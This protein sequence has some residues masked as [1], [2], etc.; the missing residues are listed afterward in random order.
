MDVRAAFGLLAIA[1]IAAIA[2]TTGGGPILTVSLVVLGL[3]VLLSLAVF[4]ASMVQ[5]IRRDQRALV[6]QCTGNPP[7][8]APGEA[9]PSGRR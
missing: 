9:T 2:W 7:P 1:G 6:R 5:E 4:F 8:P 3:I